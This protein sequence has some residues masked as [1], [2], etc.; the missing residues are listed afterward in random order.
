MYSKYVYE[1]VT[2]SIDK[3][4]TWIHVKSRRLISRELYKGKYYVLSRTYDNTNNIYNYFVVIANV[5]INDD[6]KRLDIDDYGR[7]RVRLDTIWS[8]I[9]QHG[10]TCDVNID[11][12]LI[13]ENTETVIYKINL[14]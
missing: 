9:V 12:E 7:V 11:M 5:K 8:D 6:F 10:I 14:D 2:K 3:N 13:E 1:S 4:K